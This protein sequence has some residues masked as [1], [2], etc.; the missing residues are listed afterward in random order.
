MRD[1]SGR[2]GADRGFAV[3]GAGD[4]GDFGRRARLSLW[5][6]REIIP[7]EASCR[8]WLRRARAKPEDADEVIQDAYCKLATLANFD[9]IER[10]RAYFFSIVRNL[11]IRRVKRERI[12]SIEAIA[13]IEGYAADDSWSPERQ[14]LSRLECKH[15]VSLI[16]ALPDKPRRIVELRRIEGLSQ[17]E[18]AARLSV[19]EAVVEKQVRL[20]IRAVRR[21]VR[22]G[23][24]SA[25]LANP[26]YNATFIQ[27][28]IL[29]L[30]ASTTF[31]GRRAGR[32]SGPLTIRRAD[33]RLTSARRSGRSRPIVWHD[34]RGH[35]F[36]GVEQEG[37]P[38]PSGVGVDEAVTVHAGPIMSRYAANASVPRVGFSGTDKGAI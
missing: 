27:P 5:V 28:R 24:G 18:T 1:R 26:Y 8:G 9:H 13:E 21:G 19:T 34:G 4:P 6:A 38:A 10:P 12:V 25:T 2:F 36:G 37:V 33:R 14:V 35:R 7:H 11:Y 15:V 29:G 3:T 30:S 32:G 23:A 20:G 22:I 16:E 31:Q 17:R